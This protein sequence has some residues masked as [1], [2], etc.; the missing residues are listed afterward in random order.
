MKIQQL[1][2]FLENKPGHLSSICKAVAEAGINIETLSLADTQQFGIL[3]LIVQ[4]WTKASATL[5]EMGFVV[6]ETEVVAIEVPNRPGGV[7]EI[8]NALDETD[9]N[10]EYMYAV[11][12][13]RS[14]NA[15]IILKVEDID[16]VIAEMQRLNI[17]L[18][19]GD[20]VYGA[21]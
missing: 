8:L 19:S 13:K 4:D 16:G 14:E 2:I 6:K 15:V 7:A 5:K 11:L 1:S 20:Q 18:L 9:I 21:L 17:K 3:R 10:I 12:E